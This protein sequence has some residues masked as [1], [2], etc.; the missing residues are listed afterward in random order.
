MEVEFRA[1]EFG[2]CEGLWLKCVIEELKIS[3]EFSMKMFCDNQTTISIS[4]N[5][6][7][8][9]ITKYVEIDRYY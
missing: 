1:I 8:H 6:V 9:D 2:V 3:T 5:S 4:H 7:H